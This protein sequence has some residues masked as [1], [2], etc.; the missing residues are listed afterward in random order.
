MKK[1]SEKCSKFIYEIC[2][3]TY[4][5]KRKTIE[6]FPFSLISN[7]IFPHTKKILLNYISNKILDAEVRRLGTG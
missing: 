3:H 2:A 4:L 7:G 6:K 5:A 1:A